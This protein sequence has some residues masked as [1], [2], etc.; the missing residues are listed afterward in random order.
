[1]IK[2]LSVGHASYE[3]YVQLDNFI[4]ENDYLRFINK[5]GCGGGSASNVAYLLAKWGVGSTFAGT[6][7]N[8]MYGNRIQKELQ[9]VGVDTRYIETTYDK[10]T[11]VSTVIVNRK[12]GSSTL[13]NIADEYVKLRKFDFDFQPDFI[14][15]DGHDSYASKSSIERFPKAVSVCGVTRNVG[16]V[17]DCAKLCQYIIFNSSVAQSITGI[18]IDYNNTNTLVALYDA[19]RKKFDHNKVIVTLGDHGALYEVDSQIKVSPALKVSVVDSTGAK[20]IFDGSF[21]Y[22]L[23]KGYSMEQA[24]RFANIAAG[25]SVQVVGARLSIPRLQDVQKIYDEK[26]N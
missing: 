22:G 23:T 14:Y 13:L 6:V 11:T 15:V 1:M 2:T 12:S 10:D 9:S 20:D 18:R 3:L 7:G 16:E 4:R 25:L 26:A 19:L 17:L 24:V 5:I 21:V 8:D